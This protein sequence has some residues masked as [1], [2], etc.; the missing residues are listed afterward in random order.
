[1]FHLLAWILCKWST[2]LPHSIQHYITDFTIVS[3]FMPCLWVFTCNL[4]RIIPSL[5]WFDLHYYWYVQFSRTFHFRYSCIFNVTPGSL[6]FIHKITQK[7]R[8][9]MK[10]EVLFVLTHLVIRN[11]TNIF[12]NKIDKNDNFLSSIREIKDLIT[13]EFRRCSKNVLF[14]RFTKAKEWLSN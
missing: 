1:M 5:I 13:E 7:V 6:L 3:Y 10:C 4:S 11:I 8:D 9:Y 12:D 14:P 2:T